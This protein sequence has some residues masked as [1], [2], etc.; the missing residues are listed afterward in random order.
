MDGSKYYSN[1]PYLSGVFQKQDRM[2]RPVLV[3]ETDTPFHFKQREMSEEEQGKLIQK[4]IFEHPELYVNT[5][6]KCQICNK[7][8][9]VEMA[10]HHSRVHFDE[11]DRI[12]RILTQKNLDLEDYN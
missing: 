2:N 10:D 7:F 12:N 6:V 3:A 1:N 4:R 9:E 8:I 5:H 11:D